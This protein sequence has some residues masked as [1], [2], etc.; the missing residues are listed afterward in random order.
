MGALGS[1]EETAGS[2]TNGC[3]V[4]QP[5]DVTRREKRQVTDSR[6]GNEESRYAGGCFASATTGPPSASLAVKDFF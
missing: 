3:T 2:S 1:T 6:G 5:N 4:T